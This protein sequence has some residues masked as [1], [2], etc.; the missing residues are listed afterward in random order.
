MAVWLVLL[1][2][3]VPWLGG[4]C[5]WWVGDQ[6]AHLQHRLASAFGVIG[7]VVSLGL[8]GFTS[9][10]I[11]LQLPLGSVFGDFT[12]IT[13]GLGVYLAI[14]AAVIGCREGH[15][16]RCRSHRTTSHRQQ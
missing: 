12:F 3:G 4:L 11:V 15:R 13:D 10:G 6:R 1:T 14:I 8:L 2:I 5:V 7:A 16:A 9:D